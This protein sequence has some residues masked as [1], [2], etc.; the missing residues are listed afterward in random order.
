M[1][2]KRQ[3]KTLPQFYRAIAKDMWDSFWDGT[4]WIEEKVTMIAFLVLLLI[5]VL[6]AFNHEIG[7][8]I[9]GNLDATWDGINPAWGVIPLALAVFHMFV[10][11]MHR[12]FVKIEVENIA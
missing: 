4:R 2:E 10:M 12:Q 6:M 3:I 9:A 8:S 11:A 5:S 7:G 1:G